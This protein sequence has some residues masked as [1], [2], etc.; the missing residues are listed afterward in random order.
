MGA[1]VSESPLDALLAKVDSALSV[2]A[3][4]MAEADR[5]L[6]GSPYM[7]VLRA[8]RAAV[9]ARAKSRQEARAAALAQRA[10]RKTMSRLRA[11]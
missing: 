10:G 5:T 9:A 2:N 7:A 11:S 3:D 1:P 6:S 4:V 8:N